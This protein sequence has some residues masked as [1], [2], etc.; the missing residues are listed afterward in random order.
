MKDVIENAVDVVEST[1]DVAEEVIDPNT[2]YAKLVRRD[3]GYHV[4]DFDGTEGPVCRISTDGDGTP[5]VIFTPNKS[6]R[7]CINKKKA[8]KFFD[9]G[10]ESMDLY[11]KATKH[12]GSVGTRIPNEKLISYLPKELQDE[13]HAIIARAIEAKNADK[14]QP[15]TEREKAEAKLA[16]A[17]EAYEKLTGQKFVTPEASAD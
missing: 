14:K 10:N 12:I 11:Y 1:T 7:K 15:M 8:D 13:Y 9:E 17:I 6:N 5:W 16:R 4:I 3:D 2:V